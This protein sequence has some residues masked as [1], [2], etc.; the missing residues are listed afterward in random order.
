MARRP[1]RRITDRDTEIL[2]HLSQF[3]SASA[4]VLIKRFYAEKT[5][6]AL[7]STMRRLSTGPHHV[8]QSVP[9][10]GHRYWYQLTPAGARLAGHKS[11][12]CRTLGVHASARQFALQW[13]LF[14]AG[15]NVRLIN[16]HEFPDLFPV[17]GHRLPQG[18]FYFRNM[19]AVNDSVLSSESGH[20]SVATPAGPSTQRLGYLA[21]DFSGRPLRIAQRLQHTMQ[22]F[23]RHGWFDSL[24]LNGQFEVTLLTINAARR[25][26]YEHALPEMLRKNL[27]TQLGRFRTTS[28]DADPLPF[29]VLVRAV[30]GLQDIIYGRSK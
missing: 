15:D 8:V 26:S 12:D 21:F 24:L 22:R 5:A 25:R 14:L 4:D 29:S 23:L 9:L 6:A 30:P 18:S 28:V 19:P 1:T 2:Q 7:R 16:L 13:F 17:R 3:H 27:A 11:Y 20:E 10:D